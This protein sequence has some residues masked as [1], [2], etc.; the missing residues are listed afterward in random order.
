LALS[1]EGDVSPCAILL[2]DVGCG[3]VR[4][5]TF[6]E[7]V[8]R[9]PVFQQ[10]LD[11]TQLQG[12]CG[13][14]RYKF[15]CGGCRA[16]AYYEHGDVMA[17]DPT[18]FFEPEDETTVSEHEAETNRMFKRYAFMVRYAHSKRTLIDR[19]RDGQATDDVGPLD[20]KGRA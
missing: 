3:N 20:Q 12:K 6:P 15:T 5:M 10:L 4:D 8:G 13:R 11:R 2:D 9:S 14:C 18:C 16:M 7:I 19:D 1:A 17:E